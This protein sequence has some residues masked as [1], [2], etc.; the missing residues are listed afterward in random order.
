MPQMTGAQALARQLRS[1]SVDTV[2]T[3]PGVQIMSA[4]DALYELR[5][6]IK[7]VQTRHEQ[8]TTG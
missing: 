5:N 7:L 2:F 6:D 1:E 3:L 4:F 8:A